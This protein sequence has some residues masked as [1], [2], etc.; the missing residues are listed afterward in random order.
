MCARCAPRTA[1]HLGAGGAMAWLGAAARQPARPEDALAGWAHVAVLHWHSCAHAACA[2][3]R[4]AALQGGE[5]G[6]Q[7]G[8]GQPLLA[9]SPRYRPRPLPR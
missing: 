9:V 3:P 6:P 2:V 8:C 5:R 7:R 4:C 1:T